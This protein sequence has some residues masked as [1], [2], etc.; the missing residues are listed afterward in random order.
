MMAPRPGWIDGAGNCSTNP[1]IWPMKLRHLLGLFL[2]ATLLMSAV[3]VWLAIELRDALNKAADAEA[4]Q[5]QSILLADDLRQS[6]DDLTRL[7]RLFV[8][9][10]DERFADYFHQVL[11]I[12]NGEQP[13]PGDYGSIFW[14]RVI[15]GD[16]S[17]DAGGNGEAISFQDRMARLGFTEEEFALLAEAQR[18]SDELTVIEERAFN[19]VRG[20]YDDGTGDYS[21]PGPADL[22]LAQDLLYG[23][24]YLRA[25]AAI[26]AP[27]ARFQQRVSDRTEAALAAARSEADDELV[28]IFV[29]TGVLLILLIGLTFFVH[30]R[31][32][33]RAR[34]LADAATDIA[35]GD[36]TKRS[37]VR[38]RDELGVLGKTFDDMVSR[39]ANSLALVTAAKDRMQSE[40]DVGHEIQMSMV[41][42]IFPAF[43][44]RPEFNVYAVLKPAREVGGDFYDFFFIDDERFCI[45]IGDV[46]GKGVP[47]ALFMAVAKTLI[48]SR[49]VDDFSTASILTH[50][51]DELS[52][53]NNES[54]FVT[55]FVAIVDTKT[56][57]TVFTNAGH[58]PPFV[59]RQDGT[60]LQLDQRH[61]PIVGIVPD[62]V[63]RE[64][65][66]RLNVADIMFLYTD[67]VTE[68][69]D[70]DQTIFTEQRLADLLETAGLD[71]AEALVDATVK[72]VEVFEGDV[73]QTDD[74]TILAFQFNGDPEG[75]APVVRRLAIGNDPAEI[76]KVVDAF[77]R[78]AD[79]NDIPTA[80]ARKFDIVFDEL[81]SNI[82]AYAYGDDE[83]HEIEVK[84]E[85]SGRRI[86]VIISD[87]G[88]PFNPVAADTPDIGK[89]LEDREIGGLG[90]H[91]AR[92]LVDDM[93]YQRRIGRNVT[94]LTG[95]I[96]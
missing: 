53:N 22:E 87:D 79:E 28:S 71:S 6:S 32:L 69:I 77:D 1:M 41:P 44:E 67:G 66:V 48:K 5:I 43:P 94:T 64:D 13:I 96:G 70:G 83:D 89:P 73:E 60:L 51:N 95:H 57:D 85:K 68:A 90:I 21:R 82:I 30:R 31:V 55:L 7:A 76:A 9:S 93:A 27:I 18:L 39:L 42:L 23:E 19:A 84:I 91:L 25:K 10:G 63:Y 36:L 2:A 15:V 81:L 62:V 59:R 8:Q 58:N 45:C 74:V 34:D 35:A 37:G 86:T 17:L 56:G 61:G 72:A 54:M 12:R 24:P 33:V 11:A 46:S 14:D 47:S 92:N 78:F 80:L 65:R 16:A 3:I 4:R 29:A 75:A 49:S 26:M 52:A 40:L 50:V 88:K 38:G 20:L